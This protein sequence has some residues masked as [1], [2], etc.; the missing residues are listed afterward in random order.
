MRKRRRDR[1]PKTA[2]EDRTY[3]FSDPMIQEIYAESESVILAK[4]A[5]QSAKMKEQDAAR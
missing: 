3:R 2:V 5:E 4:I 1:I